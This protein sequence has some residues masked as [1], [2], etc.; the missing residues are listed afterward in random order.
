MI[1]AGFIAYTLLVLGFGIYSARFARRGSDDYFLAGRGLGSWV[2]GLSMAASAESGWVLLGL[3]GAAFTIGVGVLWI[4]PGTV[5]AFLFSWWIVGKRARRVA[6]ET[7]AITLPDLLASRF[8]GGEATAIRAI[9]ALIVVVM[10]TAY[11][12]AQFKASGKA[13]EETFGLRPWI[14]T[15]IGAAIVLVYTIGGGFRAVAWT[16]VVQ[17]ALMIVAC[18]V[19]PALLVM[20]LGGIVPAWDALLVKDAGGALSD[21][22]A[23][24]E[25][26]ALVMFL[27]L[28]LGIPLGYPGQP[29]LIVRFMAARDDE[30]I[31]FGARIATIW[32]TL[33]FIGVIV[34]GLA[35]RAAYGTLPGGIDPEKTMP[36]VAGELLH[37]VLHGLVVAA[38]LAAICSTADSQLL[39]SASAVSHDFYVRV[40]GRRPDNVAW[41]NRAAVVLIAAGAVAFALLSKDSIFDFVLKAWG[42]LGAAFGPPLILLL[43]WPRTTAPG[44]IAGMLVGTAAVVT[45]VLTDW[46]RTVVYDLVAGFALSLAAVVLVSLATPR[47]CP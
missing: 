25:G 6:A 35:A 16:D 28:W 45:W 31:R 39:A 37:P 13:F 3:V 24:K 15:L 38:I 46:T 20:K 18:L 4:V 41:I 36:F 2:A 8:R 12:A 9:A 42:G 33:L 14:G 1:A 5:I 17:A 47:R 26:W 29:H 32:A 11:V 27:A 19:L 22:F 30:A 43:V 40:L 10:L 44:A 21:P 7:G 23:A 34:L